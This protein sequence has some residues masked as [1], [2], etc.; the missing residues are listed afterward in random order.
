MTA[1]IRA[2]SP[3]GAAYAA[4]AAAVLLWGAT[5][6]ATKI[7]V[8]GMDPVMAA[9]LRTVLAA[10]IAVPAVALFRL[11]LPTTAAAWMLLAVSAA[12]G[13]GGFTVLFSLG[14][15]RTSA[16]HAALINA[17]IPLFTGLFGAIAERRVPGRLWFVG[18]TVA[19]AGEA[20]LIFGRGAAAEGATVAGDL[21]C[22]ASSAMA[23][24]GYV[25]GSHLARD[26]GTASVTFWGIALAGLA[27]APL[28][29][30]WGAGL[31]WAAVPVEAWNAVLY[32]ALASSILGY[33]A[34]YW[35]LA[36]GGAVRMAPMQFAMPVVSLALAVVLLDESLSVTVLVASALV[37]SGIAVSRRG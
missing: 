18:I 9:F 3:L 22:V 2:I 1:A 19:F 35:A 6:V 24:L 23:G 36:R 8:A 28:V 10:A 26:I 20:V 17:S 13:F 25:A 14:V 16:A 21:L 15:E 33:V 4:A 34:W 5:P 32:L 11:P 27:Q 31:D 29:Y 12:A 7:A 30:L 37:L